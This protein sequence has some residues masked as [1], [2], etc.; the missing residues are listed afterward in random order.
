MN[1]VKSSP[2]RI[3]KLCSKTKCAHD[4]KFVILIL[5]LFIYDV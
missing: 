2:W 1:L 5:D 3:L 4:D